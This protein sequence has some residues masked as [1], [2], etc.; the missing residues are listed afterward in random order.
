MEDWEMEAQRMGM[1]YERASLTIAASGAMDSSI[2]LFISKSFGLQSE[3]L[4][5]YKSVTD[6]SP[7]GQFFIHQ[8]FSTSPVWGPLCTR[9]WAM[10]EWTLSR[11]IVFFTSGG[12]SWKCKEVQL[13][14]FQGPTDLEQY[15][16]WDA[17]LERYS[18]T[19][20]TFEKDRLIALEGL[21]SQMRRSRN[22][23]YHYGVWMNDL[24]T[25]IAWVRRSTW[26][27]EGVID[28]PS[29]SWA[30]KNGMKGFVARFDDRDTSRGVEA[31][32]TSIA[33]TGTMTVSGAYLR[34]CTVLQG[35]D[36]I[37]DSCQH[38]VENLMGALASGLGYDSDQ[39]EDAASG[40]LIGAVVLDHKNDF[41]EDSCSH[42]ESS[43]G[44]GQETDEMS[45]SDM[46]CLFLAKSRWPGSISDNPK[47]FWILVLAPVPATEEGSHCYK[48]I[49][50]GATLTGPQDGDWTQVP[51]I[52]II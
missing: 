1:L 23:D 27:Y 16:G 3:G 46:V 15:P 37:D 12:I 28:A 11:R 32:N 33:A 44:L 26:F 7:T 6:E 34:G 17:L 9:G 29:W 5:F 40:A 42:D 24:A 8:K 38:N 51:K 2:G 50:A 10:Q 20:F 45:G 21:V 35:T 13:C 25:H 48:R 36:T 43:D 31:R 41:N 18:E 47:C 39:I 30:S 14:E 52:H 19:E 49:G 4:P 22:D